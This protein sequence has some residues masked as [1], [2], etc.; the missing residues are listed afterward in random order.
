[1]L[2]LLKQPSFRWYWLGLFLSGLGD[3]FGWMGLTWYIMNKTGSSLAMG[4]VVSGYFLPGLI[5]GL[6][7]G[8]LLDRFDRKKLII[9]D[10]V[11]RGCLYILIVFILASDTAPLWV[12]YILIALAGMLAPLSNTG[13][14]T[15]LPQL[16]P[17]QKDLTKANSLMESQW[18]IIY[19]FGPGLAGVLISLVGE[20]VVLIMDAV[21]FFLCAICFSFVKLVPHVVAGGSTATVSS[22]WTDIKT[23]FVYFGKQPVLVW[24]ILTTFFFNMSYGPIEVALPLFANE[25]LG[26]ATALGMLWSSL[27]VGSL[28]GTVLFSVI[29]WRVSIGTTL[30]GII[31]LWG[32]TTLPLALSSHIGVAVIAMGFA[33]LVYAP[34]GP[35]YRTYLQK[36]VPPE[37][38]GRV[39]TAVRTITG[40]GMPLGAF[41]SGLLIPLL[42]VRG[43]FA[44]SAI[45]CIAVGIAAFRLLG[46]MR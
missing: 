27:A 45:A 18:Q 30:A 22:L 29:S 20:R 2:T 23:G 9:A 8:V 25:S 28:S 32:V 44:A 46:R 24:L 11:I 5:A 42:Q 40:L 10:N 34:Y 12:I 26:G 43:L 13:A 21:S 37:M 1:M 14:A 19:L 33:G 7:A 31:L 41:V 38:L 36:D 35:L 6:L 3:Q 16:V 15:I 4:S 17:N 39:M